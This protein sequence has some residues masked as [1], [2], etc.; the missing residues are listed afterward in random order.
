MTRRVFEKLCTKKV[1]VDFLAPNFGLNIRSLVC[2]YDVAIRFGFFLLT[3][4][5]RFGL[6]EFYLRFPL[7]QKYLRFLHRK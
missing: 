1:C 5:S 6:F 4:E 2:T 3:V 7:V